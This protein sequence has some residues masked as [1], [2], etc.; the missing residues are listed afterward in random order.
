M[1]LTRRAALLG[2]GLALAGCGGAQSVW[3]TDEAVAR[4]AYWHDG[5]PMLTLFTMIN[6]RSGQGAHS[7]IMI[8]ASQR[9]LFDPAGSVSHPSIPERNDVLFGIT[10]RVADFYARAHARE[11]YHVVI[12]DIPV[13]AAV[14]ERAMQL[15]LANGAVSQAYCTQAT[16][17]LLQ[18]LPGFERIRKTWYPRDLAEQVETLPGVT[19]R[20]LYE[21]DGDD[22]SEAI[23]AYD[24]ALAS[25][26]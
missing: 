19:T 1:I 13:S 14:A 9:V 20:R 23:R 17:G 4:A 8:N 25:G 18:R 6:N 11:T 24:A 22:K 26:Q 7:A 15:A 16:S 10:P 3:A 5:P 21:N 12:Q 2:A